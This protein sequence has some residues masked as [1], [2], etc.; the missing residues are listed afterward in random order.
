MGF[1][2]C[3]G[4]YDYLLR[5]FL[6]ELFI[7]QFEVLPRRIHPKTRLQ[8]VWA[9]DKV[10]DENCTL[11]PSSDP[12]RARHAGISRIQ[13]P[14]CTR[15]LRRYA[16]VTIYGLFVPGRCGTERHDNYRIWASFTLT[17]SPIKDHIV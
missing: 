6:S 1:S 12:Q 14:H 13:W 8:L 7:Q 9:S 11:L 10:L 3:C 4:T 2:A 16:K 17:P 15:F 5:W